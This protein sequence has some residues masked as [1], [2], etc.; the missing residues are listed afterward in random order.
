MR[1]IMAIGDRT[2]RDEGAILRAVLLLARQMR[3]AA[4]DGALTGGALALLA[5]LHRDGAMSAVALARREGLQPQSLSRLLTR[6]DMLGLI[7]RSVDPADARRHAIALTPAGTEM[8]MRQMAKRRIWLADRM[9][10]RL[11][12]EEQA[13]LLDAAALMLRIAA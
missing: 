5:T 10:E 6:L 8:L 9:A 3:R 2:G 1:I 11:S 12:S 4:D 13:R 7:A